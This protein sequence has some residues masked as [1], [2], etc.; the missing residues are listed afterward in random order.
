[1][2]VLDVGCG[3]TKR[4]SIGVDID[5]DVR[6]DVVADAKALPF[7]EEV[8][9]SVI[10]IQCI[11]HL[12]WPSSSPKEAVLSALK[13]FRR[14]LKK[15]GILD[16]TVPNFGGIS[17]LTNWMIS[18]GEGMEI[19]HEPEGYFLLG[20]HVNGAQVH[21]VAFTHRNLRIALEQA[22]FI[23]I[24]YLSSVVNSANKIKI[25]IPKSRNDLIHIKANRSP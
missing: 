10:S 7:K 9:D 12:W 8:F 24:T 15:G 20:S 18:R 6:P 2:L 4:G 1:M 19:A 13:E 11:E 17:T 22:G 14:V 25:L 23:N 5:R 3:T 21:H 16:L